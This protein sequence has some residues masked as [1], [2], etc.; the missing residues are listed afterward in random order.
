MVVVVVVVVV[1]MVSLVLVVVVV[2]MLMTMIVVVAVVR[3]RMTMLM[4]MWMVMET[5]M[6]LILLSPNAV[7]VLAE[8]L[9]DWLVGWLFCWVALGACAQVAKLC[10]TC[11]TFRALRKPLC[12]SEICTSAHLR[13]MSLMS[14]DFAS[15]EA[16]SSSEH[17]P[18]ARKACPRVKIITGAVAMVAAVAALASMHFPKRCQVPIA[19]AP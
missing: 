4:T 16:G 14:Q 2:V 3:M 7:A 13:A 11:S 12:L 10:C 19:V 17:E 8:R 5:V 9:V 6:L 18:V 1:V 15:V